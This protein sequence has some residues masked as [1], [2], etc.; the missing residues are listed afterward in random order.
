MGVLVNSDDQITKMHHV[1]TLILEHCTGV[2]RPYRTK[3]PYI[4]NNF[5]T[6]KLH[7]CFAYNDQRIYL[8]LTKKSKKIENDVIEYYECDSL[9]MSI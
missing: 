6:K 1:P 4:T 5:L 2:V 8:A 9:G 3:I 7:V